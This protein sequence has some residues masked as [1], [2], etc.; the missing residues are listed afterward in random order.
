MPIG[1]EAHN[2]FFPSKRKRIEQTLHGMTSQSYALTDELS[3]RTLSSINPCV[4]GWLTGRSAGCLVVVVVV[5]VAVVVVVFVVAVVVLP[6]DVDLCFGLSLLF[7][8][9]Y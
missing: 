5:V 7:F 2:P 9:L 8:L 1:I 4:G 6:L 3:A